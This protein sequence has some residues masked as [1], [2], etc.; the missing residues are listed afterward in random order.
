[1]S[2]TRTTTEWAERARQDVPKVARILLAV[3]RHTAKDLAQATGL[4]ESQVSERLSG[5][6]RITADELAAF[7]GFL[8]VDPGVFFHDPESFRE[9][10]RN[11]LA[12]AD[13]RSGMSVQ[14]EFLL[15]S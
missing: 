9:M 1:M 10:F 11:G 15:A 14:G 7:A 6:T 8:D 4:S 2:T 3:T 13:L 12:S 5:K